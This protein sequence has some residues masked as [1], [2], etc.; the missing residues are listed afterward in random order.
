MVILLGLGYLLQENEKATTAL[1]QQLDQ[2]RVAEQQR[3]K[4]RRQA[5]SKH[6]PIELEHYKANEINTGDSSDKI[7]LIV[8]TPISEQSSYQKIISEN[9]TCVSTA[10]CLIVTVEFYN[11]DCL[12]AIN[13]IGAAK[14]A[15]AKA[16]TENSYIE[17]CPHYLNDMTAQCMMNICSL[18]SK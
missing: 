7:P 10:Q 8:E 13:S 5:K 6:L 9:L 4:K 14:L 18:T 17:S 16:S 12:V 3:Q 1:K 11:H 2:Q 15:K